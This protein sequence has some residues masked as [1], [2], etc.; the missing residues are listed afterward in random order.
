MGS[1]R[2]P[3]FV[4][5]AALVLGATYLLADHLPVTHAAQLAWKGSGVGLLALYAALSARD[6]DGWLITAVMALGALGDVLLGAA[7]LVPGGAAFL[8]GH[9]IAMALY[10]RHYRPSAGGLDVVAAAIMI[11]LVVFAAYRL[12]GHDPGVAVYAIGLAGMVATAQLSRFP[13]DW[14]GLGAVMFLASDLLLFARA[15]PLAGVAWV[16]IPIWSLYFAGQALICVGV[17]RSKK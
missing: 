7:G 1:R 8:V 5:V 9:L 16:V 15:G 4:L 12:S 6:L 17:V 10:L 14:V 3:T 13:R 2:A 11:P